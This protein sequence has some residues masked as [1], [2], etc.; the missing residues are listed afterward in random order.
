MARNCDNEMSV[1]TDSGGFACTKA[2]KRQWMLK[3]KCHTLRRGVCHTL[4]SHI[5]CPLYVVHVLQRLGLLLRK[6]LLVVIFTRSCYAIQEDAAL[7][8]V[9]EVVHNGGNDEAN[10]RSAQHG[11][12]AYHDALR[13]RAEVAVV[14]RYPYGVMV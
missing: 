2:A 5:F 4:R 7:V 6:L 8:G 3:Q 10:S 13:R 1:W 14:S 9:S 11:E 12:D